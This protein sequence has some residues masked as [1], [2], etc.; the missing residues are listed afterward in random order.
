MFMLLFPTV[1]LALG[2]T[3]GSGYGDLLSLSVF[4]FIAFGAGAL[5]AGWLGDHWSRRG[6]MI[7]FFIG[8][9]GSSILTGLAD[10]PLTLAL[11]LAA[12]GLFASIYHPVGLAMVG[13]T[14][15]KIGRALGING[16]YGNLGVACAP[17]TAGLL[18]DFVHWRAAFI[19][20]GIVCVLTGVAFALLIRETGPAERSQASQSG[21]SL[22]RQA[23][24]RIFVIAIL[25]TAC[26]GLIFN[27]T[28]VVMPKVFDQ[29][30][31]DLAATTSEIGALVTGVIVVAA[32]T[33]VAVGY[34]LDRYPLK[35]IL[36]G[37]ALLQI[38][39]LAA[40]SMAANFGMVAVGLVVMM[41]VF[42][43]IPIVD[44]I[45]ARYTP[46]DWR[47]R[48]YAV[49]YLISLGVGATAVPLAAVL[50]NWSGEFHT[51]FTVLAVLAAVIFAVSLAL[52]ATARP[53]RPVGPSP[54]PG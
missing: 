26:G 32:F 15:T 18:V 49:R 53:P 14:T 25:V 5:P 12:I 7:V 27:S 33:Q 38:P 23:I 21:E 13:E 28:T 9:G 40:A 1:V 39:S 48:A 50:H 4:G 36:V 34:L 11:G 35:P 29:R 2:G 47:A 44:T 24:K 19:V 10:T 30:L 51:L 43:Q 54:N 31:T 3:F 37:V 52:P 16:V 46:T 17:L 42:G 22:S 20:P 8:L 6:M 45:V 41:L